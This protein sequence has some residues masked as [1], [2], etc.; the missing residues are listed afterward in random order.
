MKQLDLACA[1]WEGAYLAWEA[2]TWAI[3]HD[4]SLG[5]YVTESGK[6]RAV[7][8]PGARSIS[9]PDLTLLFEVDGETLIIHEALFEESS[10]GQA[11]RA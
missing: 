1:R 10:Y 7:Y 11:G 5:E 9:Q 3:L 6:T 2:L 4:P 8:S